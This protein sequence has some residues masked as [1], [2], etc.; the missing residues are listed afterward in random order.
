VAPLDVWLPLWLAAAV[1]G[2]LLVLVVVVVVVEEEFIQNRTRA[3]EEEMHCAL[4]HRHSIPAYPHT[5][6]QEKHSKC[7][8]LFP[9]SDSARGDV[10]LA[11]FL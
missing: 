7:W 8:I 2:W 6:L 1:E 9:H 5:N 11:K 10:F 3:E 4:G